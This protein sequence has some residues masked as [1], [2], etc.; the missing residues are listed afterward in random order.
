MQTVTLAKQ[1]M[2]TNNSMNSNFSWQKASL[3]FLD[4]FVVIGTIFLINKYGDFLYFKSIVASWV[5]LATLAFYILLWG[6]IF[7]LYNLHIF[8]SYTQV[9][10][11][12][13]LTSII[14]SLIYFLTPLFT[15]SMPKE[16]SSF[17][18]FFL[19]VFLPML[20]LRWSYLKFIMSNYNFRKKSILICKSSKLK[21]LQKPLNEIN[22]FLEIVGCFDS[23]TKPKNKPKD[24]NCIQKLEDL[25]DFIDKNKVSEIIVG[26]KVDMSFMNNHLL[27]LSQTGTQIKSYTDVVEQLVQKLPIDLYEGDFYQHFPFSQNNHNRFYL[28]FGRIGDILFSI[29]GLIG[30]ALLMP[31]IL[32][33]N[34]L[35]NRGPLFYKQER[36]GLNGQHFQIIKF[37]SMVTDAEKGGAAFAQKNDPRIT[38]FGQFLR[39]TRIDELPQ[40]INVLRGEMAVIGP[41]P[42]RQIFVDQITEVEPLYPIR[43]TVKPGLTGWAQIKYRYGSSIEDSVEKLKFDL[44]Y[45]KHRSLIVDAKIVV[46]TIGTVLFFKGQ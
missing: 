29:V 41:R 27:K 40:L 35:G 4:V 21:E 18:L 37:R 3:R 11:R 33:G 23:S 45:I 30:T 22:P 46:K 34:L 42:E 36:V 25:N 19:L 26:P 15:P 5:H 2:T 12:V 1:Y 10:R 32:L 16:R 39:K 6:S 14:V 44:Y 7:D 8:R 31:F 20:L 28:V 9:F 17:F 38:K 24:S 43:H 13:L